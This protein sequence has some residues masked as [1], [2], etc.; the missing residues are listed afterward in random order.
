MKHKDIFKPLSRGAAY[1]N[2]LIKR[3]PDGSYQI[4]VF[5]RP[6]FKA[7]GMERSDADEAAQRRRDLR[8][9]HADL[10]NNKK[11]VDP[12]ERFDNLRRAKQ[13]IYDLAALNEWRYFITLTLDGEHIDR[14]DPAQ[15]VKP[16]TKWLDNMVQRR[17]LQ[18]MIVPEYHKDGAIHFH[19]LINGDLRLSDSGTV[20]VP[21]RKKPIKRATARQKKLDESELQTVYNIDD[22]KLGFSSAISI[23]G[24]R[25]ALAKYMTKYITKDFQKIFG[26]R[27]W[28]GGKGLQRKPQSV[29]VNLQFNA[30]P[31]PEHQLPYDLGAVKYYRAPSREALN[32]FLSEVLQA[33]LNPSEARG[34][35]S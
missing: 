5:S 10:I 23:Y 34:L 22:Y 11:N 35:F 31:E 2:A 8:E 14:Y 4:T 25:D 15:I 29:A 19:G 24:E 32:D 16:V 1:K 26:R 7:G 20:K 17:D 33:P 12:R 27:Y 6:T 28:A 13:A 21:G 9:A 30:I 3:Y 18:Y